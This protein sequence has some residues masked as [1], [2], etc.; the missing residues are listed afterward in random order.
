LP[1][2]ASKYEGGLMKLFREIQDSQADI[3]RFA[4]LG[5]FTVLLIGLSFWGLRTYVRQSLEQD[6]LEP[7]WVVAA[8]QQQGSSQSAERTLR[9]PAP[10]RESQDAIDRWRRENAQ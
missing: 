6:N 2:V 1:K 5:L 4:L 8:R 7:P 10:S 9:P 3:N